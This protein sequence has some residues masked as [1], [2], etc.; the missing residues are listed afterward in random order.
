MLFAAH[1]YFEPQ[2]MEARLN[3]N[4]LQFFVIAR[5]QRT[6]AGRNATNDRF[7]GIVPVGFIGEKRRLDDEL[8]VQIE[9]GGIARAPG[10]R[11]APL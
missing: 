6:D 4:F 7:V 10:D 3:F 1:K 2:A 11:V 9:P 5:L 8:V